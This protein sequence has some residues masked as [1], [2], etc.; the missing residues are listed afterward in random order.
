M[1]GIYI[2]ELIKTSF[3]EWREDKASRLAAAMAYYTTF[4]IAP[5]LIITLG[6]AGWFFD[7]TAAQT[8][9]I[10]QFSSLIGRQGAEIIQIM[11]ES[12]SKPRD[13]FIAS[14]I[15]FITLFWGASGV[16]NAM[17]DALNTIW[18]VTP[19]PRRGLIDLIKDRTISFS[20]VLVI[21]FLL[22]VLLVISTLL[23]T[24]TTFF[25]ADAE[26][27]SVMLQIINFVISFGVTTLLFALIFKIVPDVEIVWRNVWIGAML[28]SLLFSLGRFAIGAYLGNGS[29]VSAYGAAGSLV[30]ILIWVNYSAQILFL[31]AE[32]TQ[33]YTKMYDKRPPP[34]KYA[35]PLSE[36]ARAQQGSPHINEVAH[37]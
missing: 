8:Q 14:A 37:K 7:K 13:S 29:I 22:L 11:L 31:G 24:L 23:S 16:F 12:A 2:C 21:G 36:Q 26:T 15:G 34:K 4:S 20:M 18:E 28:T 5:L 19:K 17:Q 32:F 27:I 1:N 25:I 30:V 10:A 9:L 35:I 33:V 6:I 3:K